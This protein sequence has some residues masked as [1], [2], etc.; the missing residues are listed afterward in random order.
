[1]SWHTKA[2][3]NTRPLRDTAQIPISAT[4]TKVEK[5]APTA[6]LQL[7]GMLAGCAAALAY[8]V[9]RDWRS[10]VYLLLMFVA[11]ASAAHIVGNL[12]WLWNKRGRVAV[13]GHVIAARL[14]KRSARWMPAELEVRYAYSTNESAHTGAM[15][16]SAQEVVGHY[17]SA[18]FAAE[19]L[20]QLQ[21]RAII[22]L[23]VDP[24][25]P[26]RVSA[27]VGSKADLVLT[28]VLLATSV[29]LFLATAVQWYEQH[30]V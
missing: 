9:L 7:G 27:Q 12:M 23:W 20:L 8:G 18:F 13:K 14:N 22:T 19:P 26:E 25:V 28:L 4:V 3:I 29:L 16:R 2:V 21:P 5:K 10:G 11:W 30:F 6:A 15:F 24:D 1:M 17:Y